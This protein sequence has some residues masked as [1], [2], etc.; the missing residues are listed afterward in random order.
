VLRHALQMFAQQ[1]DDVGMIQSAGSDFHG[2]HA[3]VKHAP[4]EHAPVDWDVATDDFC[5]RRRRSTGFLRAGEKLAIAVV[6]P[7]L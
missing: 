2:K 4:V 5:S 6:D 3:P 7:G 1:L